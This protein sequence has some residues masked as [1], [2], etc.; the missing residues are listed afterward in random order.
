MIRP[1]DG[2]YVDLKMKLPAVKCFVKAK[3]AGNVETDKNGYVSAG[4]V[5]IR[6]LQPRLS[7]QCESSNPWTG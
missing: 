7:N 4:R 1:K 2:S 6:P 3:A 5:G